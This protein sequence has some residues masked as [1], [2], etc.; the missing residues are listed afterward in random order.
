MKV[1][2]VEFEDTCCD[3]LAFSSAEKAFQGIQKCIW[4]DFPSEDDKDERNNLLKELENE[5]KN[6]I[7]WDIG[8][9]CS[10]EVVNIDS[11]LS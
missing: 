11:Y 3:K 4:E 9:Y 1:W 8:D 10:V 2:V 6:P 7:Y 5:Y